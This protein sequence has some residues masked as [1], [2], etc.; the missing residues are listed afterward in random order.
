M[1]INHNTI[2]KAKKKKKEE[3][4]SEGIEFRFAWYWIFHPYSHSDKW[5]K[6]NTKL[7]MER[8]LFPIP[9]SN[10]PNIHL[11]W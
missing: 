3:F 9:Y 8:I 11:K 4:K 10:I 2:W 5:F 1:K 7:K 6:R